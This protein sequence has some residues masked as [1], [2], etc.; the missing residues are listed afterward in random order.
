M[1]TNSKFMKTIATLIVVAIPLT[2]IAGIVNMITDS[3]STSEDITPSFIDIA[4][5]EDQCDSLQTDSNSFCDNTSSHL[6]STVP[7]GISARSDI[8]SQTHAFK[9]LIETERIIRKNNEMTKRL[10]ESQ[11]KI[12][13]ITPIINYKS[14]PSLGTI[15]D[16]NKKR[17]EIEK[18][19]IQMRP[20]ESPIK[21]ASDIK[22]IIDASNVHESKVPE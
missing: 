8:Y 1:E 3:N 19:S 7:M 21:S 17:I 11:K 18:E 15:R 5:I 9:V 20:I 4:E 10:I 22:T 13:S 12:K 6:D 16:F 14:T 2:F